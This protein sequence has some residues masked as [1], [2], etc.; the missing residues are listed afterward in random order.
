VEQILS[1]FNTQ[2]WLSHSDIP[3]LPNEVAVGW[4]GGADS[5]AL[6]LALQA[7][8]QRVHAWHVD[9]AW[10]DA[11]EEEALHLSEMA[12][13]WGIP[14]SS[15][16]L[17]CTPE[18]NREASA[19]QARHTQFERWAGQQGISTLCLAHHRDDQAETVCMRLL[20]GAGAG[21]CRGMQRQRMLG[22]LQVVRPL[23]HVPGLEL[24]L[25]LQQAGVSWLEDPSNSDLTIWRNRIRHRLFPVMRQ[26]GVSPDTLFLR[27][28]QQ[29]EKLAARL[30][31]AADKVINCD[32]T[33]VSESLT[34]ATKRVS[35][36]WQDWVACDSA[37]RARVLQKMMARLLG[38][39][40][41]PGRRHILLVEQWTNR[42]GRG[43]LDLSRCRLQRKRANLHLESVRAG[44]AP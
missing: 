36:P 10:R 34:E 8:G 37:V 41:T 17:A 19:R 39:G 27:W 5:T 43:G 25:A 6:L 2:T 15:A 9:H 32:K 30:D 4:S 22:T 31:I 16:R 18:A 13:I 14:F 12:E 42:N 40:I 33:G 29:A 44:F 35:L 28:Q 24:R 21:G 7:R 20:Q 26:S 38:A 1:E 3:T 11:S 23:L